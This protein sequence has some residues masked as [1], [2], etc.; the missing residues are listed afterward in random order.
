MNASSFSFSVTAYNVSAEKAQKK[1]TAIE[2]K[3][4]K[5]LTKEVETSKK[6]GHT[7]EFEIYQR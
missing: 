2:K 6:K 3:I 1:A 4:K 7:I 5:I